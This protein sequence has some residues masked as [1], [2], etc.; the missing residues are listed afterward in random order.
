MSTSTRKRSLRPSAATLFD[1]TGSARRD[2]FRERV[3]R[4]AAE[5]AKRHR[6]GRG[7]LDAMLTAL[8]AWHR[9][10]AA[11]DPNAVP[12]VLSDDDLSAAVAAYVAHGRS[13]RRAA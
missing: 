8:R 4:F 11:C 5:V 7:D 10:W 9:A 6:H 12:P 3:R 1:G 13:G 2:D